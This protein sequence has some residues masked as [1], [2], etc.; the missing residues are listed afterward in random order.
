MKEK[1][2]GFSLPKENKDLPDNSID[3]LVNPLQGKTIKEIIELKG[4]GYC[5]NH[6][7]F[8][9]PCSMCEEIQELR[10]EE[11]SLLKAIDDLRYMEELAE[12]RAK[13]EKL[14]NKLTVMQMRAKGMIRMDEYGRT[15]K[16][17]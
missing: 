1:F 13:N 16:E 11:K 4:L 8:S 3:N 14:I 10:D 15:I 12:L 7:K 6:P 17:Y 5:K 9:N 2:N